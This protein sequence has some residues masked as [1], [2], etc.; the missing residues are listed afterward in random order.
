MMGFIADAAG[1]D[2]NL[3]KREIEEARFVSRDE[4]LS[5]LNGERRDDL[6]L[7]PKFTIARQL[8]KRWAQQ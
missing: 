7:P 4:I 8:I 5:L 6:R 1:R 2:L 3:D